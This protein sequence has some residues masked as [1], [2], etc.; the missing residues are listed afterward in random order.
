M[1]CRACQYTPWAAM[2]SSRGVT[3]MVVKGITVLNS[4]APKHAW[5]TA[6]V[7]MDGANRSV[8]HSAE[9][10]VTENVKAMVV[11][12]NCI[13]QWPAFNAFVQ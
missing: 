7:M 13:R 9:T 10:T 11:E 12:V 5:I 3:R 1:K 4:V 2:Y 8:A 6:I